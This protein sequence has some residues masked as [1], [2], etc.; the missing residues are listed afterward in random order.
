MRDKKI[1]CPSKYINEKLNAVANQYVEDTVHHLFTNLESLSS[2]FSRFSVQHKWALSGKYKISNFL[3]FLNS[4]FLINMKN[5]FFQGTVLDDNTGALTGTKCAI[6]CR[7]TEQCTWYSYKIPQTC[8]LFS[9]CPEID[10]ENTDFNSFEV[11]C[12]VAKKSKEFIFCQFSK[13]FLRQQRDQVQYN[14]HS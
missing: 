3:V 13:S 10:E 2:I 11:G 9:T 4:R 1:V 7:N 8:I 14:S 6:A 12:P 5:L